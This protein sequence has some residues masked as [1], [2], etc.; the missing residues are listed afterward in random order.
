[1]VEGRDVIIR[2][3]LAILKIGEDGILACT[4]VA[5]LFDYLHSITERMWSA[6]RL[7]IVSTRVQP[8]SLIYP[9]SIP[10]YR[11]DYPCQ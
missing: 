6:E 3:A 9:S 10:K 7:I 11:R 5:D 4:N 2:A 8:L 1:M